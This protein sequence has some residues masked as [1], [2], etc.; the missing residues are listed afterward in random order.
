M[1][2]TATVP[3][4]LTETIQKNGS[5]NV[6][7]SPEFLRESKAPKDAPENLIQAIVETNRTR[8]DFAEE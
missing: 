6:L 7:F 1:I 8:K 4:C 5:N 2:I 3:V